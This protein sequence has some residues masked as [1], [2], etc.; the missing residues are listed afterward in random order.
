[1]PLDKIFGLPLCSTALLFGNIKSAD[2]LGHTKK[3]VFIFNTSTH[4]S[5]ETSNGNILS[6]QYS[7]AVY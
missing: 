7:Q 4:F 6:A 5:S 1:M 2:T 3:K